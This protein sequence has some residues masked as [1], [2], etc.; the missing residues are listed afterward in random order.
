MAHFSST[1]A[2]YPPL[3]PTPEW[4]FPPRDFEGADGGDILGDPFS[5]D[6]VV[7]QFRHMK[8]TALGVDAYAT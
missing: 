3:S 4:L 2:E 6:E 8:N 1:N 5:P 7:Q